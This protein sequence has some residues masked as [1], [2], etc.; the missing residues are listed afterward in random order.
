MGNELTGSYPIIFDGVRAGELTIVRDGVFW[1]FNARAEPRDEF[2]RLSVFGEGGEGYLGI[3]EPLEDGLH[4]TKRLSR[5]ALSGFPHSI[6]HAGKKGE[7]PKI[8]AEETA[9]L[10]CNSS[11]VNE[12]DTFADDCAEIPLS[13]EIGKLSPCEIPHEVITPPP[14]ELFSP[15]TASDEL[16]WKPCACPCAYFSD[17]KAKSACGNIRGALSAEVDSIL[18]LAV[19]EAIALE[20]PENSPLYFFKSE[21]LFGQWY[22]FLKIENGICIK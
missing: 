10:V 14:I 11:A 4:L 12:F 16:N 20:L 13:A 5:S 7:A 15:L 21:E 9:A 1:C 19:P 3:M 18:L 17:I 8:L 6:S 2:V 22:R